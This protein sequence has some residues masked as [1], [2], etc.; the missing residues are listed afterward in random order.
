MS[1]KLV[2]INL[3][4]RHFIVR[5]LI[6]TY[7]CNLIVL[8]LDSENFIFNEGVR[9][10]KANSM[11]MSQGLWVIFVD[12]DNFE[13]YFETFD[14]SFNS[15]GFVQLEIISILSSLVDFQVPFTITS[16]NE[17]WTSNESGPRGVN[18]REFFKCLFQEK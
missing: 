13:I 16:S 15:V 10:I 4:I 7:Y 14:D 12:C 5:I 9:K 6:F 1:Q 11:F 8:H 2:Q 17:F 18:L 3:W